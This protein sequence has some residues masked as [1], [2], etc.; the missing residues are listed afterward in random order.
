MRAKVCKTIKTHFKNNK[1]YKED[2]FPC[3]DCSTEVL[4][5][6]NHLV[7]DCEKYDDLKNSLDLG[8]TEGLVIFFQ[9]IVQRGE[10]EKEE[11]DEEQK[12]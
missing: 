11:K 4:D 9:R 7:N 6:S 10:K 8:K 5:T 3:W 1:E 2:N 12:G